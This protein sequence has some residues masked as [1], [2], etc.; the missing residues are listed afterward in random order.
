M[1]GNDESSLGSDDVEKRLSE[2]LSSTVYPAYLAERAVDEYCV[3]WLET[4]VP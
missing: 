2:C 3:S 4:E 1:R